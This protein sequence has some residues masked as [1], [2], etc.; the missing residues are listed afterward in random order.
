MATAIGKWNE[1]GKRL[2]EPRAFK[3]LE[4]AQQS[5]KKHMALGYDTK[6]IRTLKSSS[7]YKYGYRYRIVIR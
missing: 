3:T 6:I 4:G 2:L 5:A 7:L 1:S